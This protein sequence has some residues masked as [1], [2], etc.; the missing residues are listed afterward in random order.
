MRRRWNIAARRG[1]S[2]IL[3]L[4]LTAGLS[5]TALA[6]GE[7]VPGGGALP[8]T[9]DETFYATLDY[10]GGI[11]DSSVVKSY[12]TAGNTAITDYGVYD[13]INNLTDDSAPSV[14]DGS[15][16]F[17]LGGD[18]PSRFYFEGKT[19]KPL[20]EFPWTLSL[21]YA[22]NGVPT[23]AEDLAGKGGLVEI[24]LDALP[25]TAASEYLRNNL[26]LSAVS[27]FNGDDI[28][29]LEA[30]GAQVQLVGNLYCVLYMVMPG[31]EQHFTIRVG[32][33]D[34]SYSG[35]VFLAV[36]ATLDQLG[37]IA[38]LREAKEKAEDS[39]HAI[40]D[41]MD[42]ILDSLEGMSGNLSATANGLDQLNKARGTISG[43]KGAVYDSLDIALDAAG[44][45]T[46][47]MQPMSGHLSAAQQALTDTTTLLNEMNDNLQTLKPE[48]EN[49]RKILKSLQSDLDELQELA[50]DLE[51]YPY[52]ARDI[53][54]NLSRDLSALGT[55]L[56]NLE[57]SMKSM[58]SELSGMN[59]S[60]SDVNGDSEVKINGKS[61]SD[62][63]SLVHQANS[64]RAA[65][66][67]DPDV[68][69]SI[70]FTEFM[71][72][73][74]VNKGTDPEEAAAQA[75]SLAGLWEQSQSDEFSSQL[76]QA[77]ELNS[78]LAQ[79]NLTVGQ[80]KGLVGTV[81]SKGGPLLKQLESLCAALGSSSLSGDL[82][83][84]SDM[85]DDMM[86]DI[87]DHSGTL[88][89]AMSTLKSAAALGVRVSENADTALDQVQSLT[90]IMNTY[91]PETQ[92]ALEDAKA[93]S[94]SAAVSI[95]ALVDASRSAEALLKASG[96]DLDAGTQ[97]A[98]S[99]LAA[100]L[101]KS[102]KGLNQT[103]TIR[104]AKDTID[105]LITDEWDSHT[106]E[107]NN[108]LLMD[109]AARPISLTDS[110]NEGTAS[111]QYVIRTQEIK[112]EK[113]D[114]EAPAKTVSAD[115]GTLWT[116]IA[117]MFK[118]IW[119]TITGWFQ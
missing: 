48:V 91:Q 30:E 27:M 86:D 59:E 82:K 105:A 99:N 110:R 108:L 18:A 22:L 102:T 45:L 7:P 69:G 94:D 29:S 73:C 78:I 39:Y 67:A 89:S 33:D 25:N 21:S 15:V 5:V 34:F 12:K 81:N 77:E 65:Y 40:Q 44:P 50:D 31:E 70:S 4:V 76:E 87:D 23:K 62:I 92:Q 90:D 2:L 68:S 54:R 3:A 38:D 104:H 114:E 14:G 60:L 112:V 100:A 74:F 52:Q 118:D 37:Q 57:K 13:Q 80:M 85:M 71:T 98:L 17:Q 79:F 1:L 26:V 88:S 75:S 96:T 42:V 103:D 28:L 51:D 107:D 24:T 113:P 97:K 47:S 10:Y 20:E 32:T 93:F 11:L 19:A 35:M 117:D 8:A 64:L 109:A 101:R 83:R 56:N 49:T 46:E 58:R 84:L 116:R 111:I 66:E 95:S 119:R 53:A 63:K 106:G 115:K 16:T 61:V 55:S 36:P 9:H 72:A 41:S 43:G 6:D